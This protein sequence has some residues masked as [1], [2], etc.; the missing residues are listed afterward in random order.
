VPT[1]EAVRPRIAAT[2]LSGYV[3][4]RLRELF[5]DKLTLIDWYRRTPAPVATAW[6]QVDFSNSD[7]VAVALARDQPGVVLNIGAMAN[8]DDCE[9]ERGDRDGDAWLSNATAPGVLARACRAADVRFIQVSTDYVFDGRTGP[10][11]ED[12]PTNSAA[13]WYGETKLAGERAVLEA[14]GDCAIARIVLPYRRP[15]AS[16]TDL[17]QLIRTRLSAGEPFHAAVDQLI[18][19]TLLDDIAESLVALALSTNTGVYHLAGATMLSPYEAA[20]IVARTFHLDEQLVQRSVLSA[21][22]SQANRAPRPPRSALLSDRFRAD[23]SH[24]IERPL[25]GFAE[26]VGTLRDAAEARGTE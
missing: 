23:F 4:T 8:V 2:G 11:R 7:A 20:L 10:Y 19:P 9:R 1:G 16:R 3:G 5:Y 22:T 21:I 13:N 15:P 14:G 26:G 6:H 17:P 25:R 12:S 24:V 18:T